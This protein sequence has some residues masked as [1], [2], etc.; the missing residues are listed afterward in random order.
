[1]TI[2]WTA[3]VRDDLRSIRAWLDKRNQVAA[4]RVIREIRETVSHA[5]PGRAT[6]WHRGTCHPASSGA[7]GAPY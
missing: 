6:Q 4:G 1:M 5:G 2:I 7:H 3:A